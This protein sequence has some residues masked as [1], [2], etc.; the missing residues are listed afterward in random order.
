MRTHI[1]QFQSKI[2]VARSFIIFPET[3]LPVSVLATKRFEGHYNPAES[4]IDYIRSE[5]KTWVC[6]MKNIF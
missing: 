1:C 4:E 5:E 6:S 2:R 3:S